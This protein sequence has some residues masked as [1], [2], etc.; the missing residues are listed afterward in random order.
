M[1]KSP[2]SD[3]ADSTTSV[4]SRKGS[5]RTAPFL[6]MRIVPPRSTTNSRPEPSA[7]SATK[8]GW[9]KP[10]ATRS[11]LT[12]KVAGSNGASVCARVVVAPTVN[13]VAAITAA[14]NGPLPVK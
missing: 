6:T 4:M 7:A 9:S 5:G 2:C 12:A 1:L 10:L 11:S 8:T 13:S 14:S 3:P